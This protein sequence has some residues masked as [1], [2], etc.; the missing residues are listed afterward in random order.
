MFK[1]FG[2]AL[3][4]PLFWRIGMLLWSLPFILVAVLLILECSFPVNPSWVLAVPL[5]LLSFG[6][7]I[8]YS[9]LAADD[10]KIQRR[11]DLIVVPGSELLVI[12]VLLIAVPFY[13]LSKLVLRKEERG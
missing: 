7:W 3:E 5:G 12:A 2:K 10:A 13:E 6:I 1:Y 8:A 9:A 4:D 11:S